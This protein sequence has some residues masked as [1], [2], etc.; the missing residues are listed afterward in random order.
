MKAL[1]LIQGVNSKLYGLES[2]RRA[3]IDTGE[4]NHVLEINSES[5]FDRKLIKW[6][7]RMPYWDKFGDIFKY[8]IQ[9]KKRKEICKMVRRAIKSFQK[10]G[11]NVDI[12]AH[13]LG[14][15]IAL[16]CGS[17]KDNDPVK[18]HKLVLMGSPMGFTRWLVGAAAFVRKHTRKYLKNFHALKIEYV[19][20][21]KDPVSKYVNNKII[22]ILEAATAI[23]GAEPDTFKSESDHSWITYLRDWWIL[24]KANVT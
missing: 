23:E 11:F 9:K 20:S 6:L 7:P 24:S 4:Y 19:W 21:S 8:Y 12:F 10:E 14:C 22:N 5:V 17:Q 18:I 2:L 3:K 13:S 1:I 16:S 15:Q